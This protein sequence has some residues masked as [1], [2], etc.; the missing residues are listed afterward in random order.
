MRIQLCSDLHLNFEL[1]YRGTLYTPEP[2][3]PVLVVAGDTWEA[4]REFTHQQQWM[5]Q[6]ADRFEHVVLVTGNHDYYGVDIQE[7]D[8]FVRELAGRLGNVHFLQNSSVEIDGLR[9]SGGT[10]WTDFR[11]RVYPP[12]NEKTALGDYRRIS[13]AFQ[14][15]EGG[16]PIKPQ[17]ILDKHLETVEYLSGAVDGRTVVVTHHG[18]SYRS[19]HPRWLGQFPDINHL[20]YS[21]LDWLIE[22]A[23]PL[24]WLHGHTHDCMDYAIGKTRVCCNP[25]GYVSSYAN[26]NPN[27]DETKVIEVAP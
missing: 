18:P 9:F 20:F 25:R 19:C 7:H 12:G 11:K 14:I 2:L 6:V 27:F 3:A 8:D 21:D 22:K 17:T 13:D 10:L 15:L 23:Q 5:S 24:A 26:E 1:H 4:G 16:K